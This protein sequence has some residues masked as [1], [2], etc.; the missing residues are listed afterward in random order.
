MTNSQTA[1]FQLPLLSKKSQQLIQHTRDLFKQLKLDDSQLP[2]GDKP[3]D[4]P[5]R[6][7]FAGQYS[8]GKSTI[9]KMLTG[10]QDIVI[11]QQISTKQAHS[12]TWNGHEVI[13][14]PG[15]HTTLRPQH[16]EISYQ[17]ISQADM[18]VYVVTYQLFDP[19]I[20]E[21]FRA[22][23]NEK[24]KGKEMILVVNKMADVGN[25]EQMQA[26]KLEELS[27]ITN[28]YTPQE[29]RTTF[30]DAES[31][32]NS[33]EEPPERAKRMQIRSNHDEFI[34]T[35]NRFVQEKGYLLRLTTPLEQTEHELDRAIAQYQPS[36]GDTD[37][38]KLEE[39]Y[40]Q[41]K[42]NLH[43]TKHTIYSQVMGLINGCVSQIMHIGTDTAEQLNACTDEQDA[44][45]ILRD[46]Y[47]KVDELSAQL[48][49][50][51]AE[52]IHRED[53]KCRQTIADLQNKPW[54]RSLQDSLD[55]RVK[56]QD[57]VVMKF[58]KSGRIKEAGQFL[59]K[60]SVNE[61]A[62]GGGLL[63]FSGS[64]A[65]EVVKQAGHFFGKTFKP[66]EAV[67]IAKH[68]N[69]AG[70]VLGVFGVVL[71]IYLLYRE[72]QKEKEVAEQKQQNRIEIRARFNQA[73]EMIEQ[74]FQP[75][76][77]HFLETAYNAPIK[78]LDAKIKAIQ[79]MRKG[80]SETCKQLEKLQADCAQLINEIQQYQCV[81]PEP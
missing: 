77:A 28:P 13:D 59:I 24:H 50:D 71:S 75:A 47:N 32:V 48:E 69:T 16:D 61:S 5:I 7:V 44:G 27:K 23:L 33:K 38:D 80:K 10:R 19:F 62:V 9:V 30:L 18:L 79:D 65:H 22:L 76:L 60:N 53:E 46:A 6:I 36:T 78:E 57:G 64:K 43:S 29:L 81:I 63:A 39:V 41:Q 3:F 34:R 45:N 56:Q 49:K 67:K 74:H 40:A 15:I 8:A 37:F 58:L 55:R 73:A 68:I 20:G 51:I 35:L 70:K 1:N 12:Y 11:G 21:K 25:T 17:A 66:W 31:Y 2:S 14:T 52:T 72:E 4:N 42:Y 26:I 54:V